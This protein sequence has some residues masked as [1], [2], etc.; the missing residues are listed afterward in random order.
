[1]HDL[2]PN[3]L[4][5]DSEV[6]KTLSNVRAL[7]CVNSQKEKFTSPKRSACKSLSESHSSLG[8]RTSLLRS[9]TQ[10]RGLAAIVYS[11]YSSAGMR[12]LQRRDCSRLQTSRRR[13]LCQRWRRISSESAVNWQEFRHLFSLPG[14]RLP[15]HIHFRGSTVAMTHSKKRLSSILFHRESECREALTPS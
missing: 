5:S 4:V 7:S 14:G 8:S 10:M 3:R 1:M 9:S 6:G 11:V 15:S 2:L 12:R 13:F